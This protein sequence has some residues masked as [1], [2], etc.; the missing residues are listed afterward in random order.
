MHLLRQHVMEYYVDWE[1]IGA[2]GG[3]SL[4]LLDPFDASPREAESWSKELSN[5]SQKH[6]HSYRRCKNG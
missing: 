2:N 1:I 3:D 5:P 6:P 4:H